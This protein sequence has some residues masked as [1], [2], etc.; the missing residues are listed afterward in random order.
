MK[1]VSCILVRLSAVLP[2]VLARVTGL[3]HG[4]ITFLLLMPKQRRRV[5]EVAVP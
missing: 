2:L 1:S 4:F 3:F 5:K